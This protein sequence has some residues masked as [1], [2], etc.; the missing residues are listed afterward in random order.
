MPSLACVP[1][2]CTVWVGR[3]CWERVG[4]QHVLKKVTVCCFAVLHLVK[5][6][7]KQSNICEP[8][9]ALL[10]QTSVVTVDFVQSYSI[11]QVKIEIT[12]LS[13]LALNSQ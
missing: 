7:T 12:V 10:T 3:W 4:E 8:M 6:V 1:F 2:T 5:V 13:R 9:E 11:S